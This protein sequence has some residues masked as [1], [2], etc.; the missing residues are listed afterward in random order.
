MLTFS[1][2]C[3]NSESHLYTLTNKAIG[4]PGSTDMPPG[5]YAA[6][7]LKRLTIKNWSDEFVVWSQH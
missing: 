4:K 6:I 3:P 7:R 2:Y 5:L 1:E